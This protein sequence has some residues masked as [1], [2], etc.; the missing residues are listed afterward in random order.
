MT[1]D[2][3]RDY[4]VGVCS[5]YSAHRADQ[6]DLVLLL[7]LVLL[8]RALL[9]VGLVD[10]REEDTVHDH[11][12]HHRGVNVGPVLAGVEVEANVGHEVAHDRQDDHRQAV[13]DQLIHLRSLCLAATKFDSRNVQMEAA[14]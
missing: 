3:S 7:H 12:G 13:G 4:N 2:P 9:V 8:Q 11:H 5:M 1:R 6:E 10:E 14:K